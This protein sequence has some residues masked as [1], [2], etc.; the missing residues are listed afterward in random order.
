M[1]ECD[2]RLGELA[3]AWQAYL[4]GLTPGGLPREIRYTNS[5]GEEWSNSVADVLTHVALHSSHHRG[6]VASLLRGA[7]EGA[8]Y[9][10][11]IEC[12]RRGYLAHGWPA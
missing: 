9:T 4:A 6:Q 12:I 11:Y 10:D 1:A 5:S 3:E 7:G 2:R 8:A